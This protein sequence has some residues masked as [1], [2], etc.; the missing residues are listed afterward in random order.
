MPFVLMSASSVNLIRS[1]PRNVSKFPSTVRSSRPSLCPKTSVTAS[2][3]WLATANPGPRVLPDIWFTGSAPRPSMP[4][5]SGQDQRKPPDERTVKL[6][7]SM[8]T[9]FSA[10]NTLLTLSKLLEYFKNDFQLFYNPH[11]HK[12]SCLRKSLFIYSHQPT[13]ICPRLLAGSHTLQHFGHLLSPG[14]GFLS[15]EM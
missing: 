15:L 11:C 5:S 9:N 4:D 2:P 14:D 7:K 8:H 1:A 10:L 3:R 12:R 13:P 6:G